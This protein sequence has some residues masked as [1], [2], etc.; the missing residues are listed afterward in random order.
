LFDFSIALPLS[1]ILNKYNT[2]YIFSRGLFMF[3]METIKKNRLK[4][5]EASSIFGLISAVL[6][7]FAPEAW[8]G[9]IKIL[10]AA[11]FAV[12]ILFIVLRRQERIPILPEKGPAY[13][14]TIPADA[15]DLEG[16]ISLAKEAFGSNTIAPAV[17][18]EAFARNEFFIAIAKDTT[19]KIIGFVDYYILTAAAMDQILG[20]TIKESDF[21]KDHLAPMNEIE[22]ARALYIGGIYVALDSEIERGRVVGGLVTAI[23]KLIRSKVVSDKTNVRMYAAAYG[24]KGIP[25]LDRLGFNRINDAGKRADE[26]ALYLKIATARD[27]KESLR[28]LPPNCGSVKIRN[29]RG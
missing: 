29:I 5:A 22:A 16:A 25:I 20:G 23:M 9:V 7:F 21:T 3:S 14:I 11:S 18:R 2:K 26:S 19:G 17:V 12:A 10:I 4:I 24:S 1:C 8:S 6:S 28:N 13:A 27:I 15:A